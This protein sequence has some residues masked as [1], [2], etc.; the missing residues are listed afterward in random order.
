M[1][2]TGSVLPAWQAV[3]HSNSQAGQEWCLSFLFICWFL[4]YSFRIVQIH[5]RP[6][7]CINW[8]PWLLLHVRL[9]HSLPP[10]GLGSR[11]TIASGIS[12]RFLHYFLLL[13]FKV[14]VI[15]IIVLLSLKPG[16]KQ[17]QGSHWFWIMVIVE[18]CIIHHNAIIIEI[19]C[20][21]KVM[22]FNNPQ[23]IH[24][25]VPWKN[26]LSRNQ[27]LVPKRLGTAALD[28]WNLILLQILRNGYSHTLLVEK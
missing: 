3:G 5:L 15:Q 2:I 18:L 26:C 4:F 17:A 20:T 11:M 12:Q 9:C 19:K 13:V 25:P 22:H 16:R 21:I 24:S 8:F 28:R 7:V 23:I 10:K 27:S 6:C 1:F 14:R